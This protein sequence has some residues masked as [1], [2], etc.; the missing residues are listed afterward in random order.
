MSVAV[1]DVREWQKSFDLRTGRPV[2]V[3]GPAGKL[4]CDVLGRRPYPGDMESQSNRWVSDTAVDLIEGYDPR[5]AFL[6][7]GHPYFASRHVPMSAHERQAMI[8]DTFDEI[9]RFVK[10]SGFTP[11][12]LGRGGMVPLKGSIDVSGLDGLAVSSHWSAR[13]AGLHE[14]STKDLRRLAQN[15]H[16]KMMVSKKELL[17]LF[18][19]TSDDATRT[20][21]YLLVAEEGYSFR[22][23]G[24]TLRPPVMV[25]AKSPFI[26]LLTDAGKVPSITDIRTLVEAKLSRE[27]VALI[28]VEGAGM[29]DFPKGAQPCRNGL[30]WYD[31][32]PGDAQYLAVTTGR[33]R[34]FDYPVG[35]K[36][37]NEDSG[38]REFPFSGYF[39]SMPEGVLGEDFPGKSIA[40][41]NKS[42][43]MH[44]VTGADLCV[45]CFS[46]NLFNQGVMGVI[47]RDDKGPRPHD[48]GKK[49]RLI[50]GGKEAPETRGRS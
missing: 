26:P 25:P 2:E 42:M 21:E 46:R 11:V 30:D 23:F 36:Y 37:Y 15:P 33:H 35:Y 22:G 9:D 20:P 12:I 18:N 50:Q 4:V 24:S 3:S 8:G 14:A 17:R 48:A 13:Y 16:V 40:V 47:H 10:M 34:F 31:Y 5:F 43:F 27:R 41:G 19:G 32:D 39:T 28:I 45:E 7:Y 1:I 6:V 49:M 44:T 38:E 29:G